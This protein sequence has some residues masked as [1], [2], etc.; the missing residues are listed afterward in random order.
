MENRLFSKFISLF[1]KKGVVLKSSEVSFSE[2]RSESVDVFEAAQEVPDEI[3]KETCILALDLSKINLPVQSLGDLE[4][5]E[6][7]DFLTSIRLEDKSLQKKSAVV[8]WRWD[9]DVQNCNGRFCKS[10]IRVI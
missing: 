1:K 7:I 2:S 9:E 5:Q 4:G 3:Q 8:S 10:M 6:V